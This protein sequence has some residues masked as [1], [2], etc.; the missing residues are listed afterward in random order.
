MKKSILILSVF[1]FFMFSEKTI[2]AQCCSYT[3]QQQ[4]EP[5]TSAATF[6]VALGDFDGDTDLDAVAISAYAGIDVYFNN[7]SGTFTL[8]AQY[9][10]GPDDDF[11]G[12]HVA[13]VDNDGDKDIIAIPFYTS[14][15]TTILKNNGLGVFTVSSFASNI[16][17]YNAAIGDID[18]DGDIDIFLP[19]AGGGNG[20]VLKNNGTGTYSLFQTVTAA[21]GHDAALGDLDGDG[22]LDAF[23]IE[24]GSYGNSVF[25]NNGVGNFAQLGST[26]GANGSRVALAD[27]DADGDL[28]AWVGNSSNFSEIWLNNGS[29]AFTL[30]ATITTG[31]YC[32]G[33]KLFDYDSDGDLD[34]F[35]SF[36]SS[37][38]QVWANNGSLSFS[39]CYQAP[40]G[41]S[42]H[43][44]AIGDINNDTKMDMYSGYFSN[45]DGDYV[46]LNTGISASIK[47]RF[48]PYCYDNT[49]LENVMLIGTSGGTF[50]SSPA[51]LSLNLSTGGIIPSTS[52]P[53]T[54]TVT[55][56]VSGCTAT[57]SVVIDTIDLATSLNLATI[58]ANQTGAIYQW[59][60]C[61]NGDLP[62]ANQTNQSYTP[63]ANG[64]YAVIITNGG[65]IDTS[66]CVNILTVGIS[67]NNNQNLIK[68][69]PN[70]ALDL[71]TVEVNSVLSGQTYI[72]VD[73][74]GRTVLLGKLISD[75]SNINIKE[76]AAGMYFLKVG[77][78]N[79]QSF[80][81]LKK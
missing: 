6:G 63:A 26:F 58:T 42:S 3:Y 32:K 13:D 66:A 17:T 69:Y 81:V 48:S 34:V 67:E 45:D 15:N 37:N 39:L 75:N 23:V 4:V 64:D 41:S 76:L 25:M 46:F 1:S 47:Y 77:E 71:I 55:Y 43:G 19:N 8:S 56:I 20:K 61:N 7:G 44:M 16:S 68:I 78:Q 60:D 35:A 27:F 73:Q 51:G 65:C 38:P 49:A 29:G 52:I 24:N 33:L 53:G 5:L 50:S 11:Y 70:P 74:T 14:T 28:D 31:S 36:Y 72:I 40:V 80:K 57:T 22:D 9:A 2:L 10:I 62:I 21:R 54:Y 59:I 79:R 30:G 18:G 12:V